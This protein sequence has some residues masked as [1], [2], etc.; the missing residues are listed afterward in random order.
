LEIWL[1]LYWRRI[2][3]YP[4]SHITAALHIELFGRFLLAQAITERLKS[5]MVDKSVAIQASVNGNDQMTLH[6]TFVRRLV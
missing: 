3:G 5:A 2:V 1:L 6:G 4:Q